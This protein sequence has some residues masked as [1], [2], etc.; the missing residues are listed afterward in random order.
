MYLYN[1]LYI[2]SS[3][4]KSK[5]SLYYGGAMDYK[6]IKE[7]YKFFNTIVN[8]LVVTDLDIKHSIERKVQHTFRVCENVQSI[9]VSLQLSDNELQIGEAIGLFH[10]I[11]RFEQY[12]RHRTLVDSVKDHGE[13]GILLLENY[14]VL[15]FLS[16]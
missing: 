14:G 2:E 4:Y 11:G 7:F 9:G 12:I 8:N 3:N 10:D 16:E 15:N 13:L 1:T 6:N 5:K